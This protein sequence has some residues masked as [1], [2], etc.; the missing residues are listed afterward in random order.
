MN[1]LCVLVLCTFFAL[2]SPRRSFRSDGFH[3][4][5]QQQ[6][7]SL[8]KD[9]KVIAEL[10]EA[11]VPGY[12]GFSRRGP[13]AGASYVAHPRVPYLRHPRG[14]FP[15][16]RSG[17]LGAWR[18]YEPHRATVALRDMGSDAQLYDEYRPKQ[19]A[20]GEP[21]PN[22]VRASPFVGAMLA[23]MLSASLSAP[24]L[25]DDATTS[26]DFKIQGGGASTLQSGR[27]ITITRGVN[28]DNTNWEGEDL[29][30]VA[31]QQSVVRSANFQRAK[32]ATAS[33]FDADLANSN[34]K[35]A[36]MQQVN[37]EM[38]DL[39]NADL[40]NVDLTNAYLSGAV[41]NGPKGAL[42]KIDNTDW[43][44]AELR[45]DQRKYLCTVAKGTNPKTGVP[46]RESLLCPDALQ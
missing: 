1:R 18:P 13:Q 11:L 34:F 46:T 5:A 21:Q 28:L 8:T 2:G 20:I 7:K 4:V 9:S 26:G 39:T 32:L 45:K 3:Y 24:V 44:D 35:D 17:G 14:Q 15:S 30:G 40:T 29:K 42:T 43:T 19:A 33:F 12:S 27:R 25:A 6:Y 23:A 36:D 31:F 22:H 10:Q 41:L 16:M 37:L 38:A